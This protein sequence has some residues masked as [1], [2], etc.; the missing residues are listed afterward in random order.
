MAEDQ[1]AF[2]QAKNALEIEK[3]QASIRKEERDFVTDQ[4]KIAIDLQEQRRKEVDTE[5]KYSQDIPQ[6]GMGR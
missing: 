5:L 4:Q 2:Q 6:M 3:L 1:K